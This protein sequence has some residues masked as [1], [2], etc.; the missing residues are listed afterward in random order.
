MTDGYVRVAEITDGRNGNLEEAEQLKKALG[1]Q[2]RVVV[3]YPDDAVLVEELTDVGERWT[4]VA[5]IDA[6]YND[7]PEAARLLG[8]ELTATDYRV[9]W[10]YCSDEGYLEVQVD[11]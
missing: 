10:C 2:H 6:D 5:T 8:D 7:D 11:E 3:R 9:V 4:R 1:A